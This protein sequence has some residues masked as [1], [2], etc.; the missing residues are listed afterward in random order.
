MEPR[1]TAVRRAEARTSRSERIHARRWW[2]LAVLDLAVFLVVLDDTILNVALPTLQR[3]LEATTSQLQWFLDSYLIVFGGLLLAAGSLGDRFGRRGALLTGWVVFGAGSLGAAVSTT[4]EQLITARCAMGLGAACIMPTTLSILT[5][6]FPPHERPLAIGLWAGVIGIGVGVGPVVSGALLER[7]WWGSVFLIN[8]P[9]VAVGLLST[10]TVVPDS[11]DPGAPRVDWP[12]V[13]LSTAGV[14]TL[15]YAIIEAPSHGWT[16][17]R[18]LGVGAAAVAVI[19][20][21]AWWERRADAPMIDPR[22]FRSARFTAASLAI[23]LTFFAL[24]G[25]LFV[26]TQQLQFVLGYSALETGLR[27]APVAV[28]LTV[29]A[30][31]SAP[32]AARLGAKARVAAGLASVAAGLAFSALGDGEYGTLLA[33]IAAVGLGMGL[34]M[35]PATDAV[36]GSLPLAKAGVGSAVND[37]TRQ[38]GAAFGVAVVGSVLASQYGDTLLPA[39]APLPPDLAEAARDSVGA[40]LAIAADAGA[41]AL[42]D[43]AREAYREAMRAALLVAAG[44]SA[45]GAA[46]ALAFLPAHERRTR[47]QIEAAF[48]STPPSESLYEWLLRR[49]RDVVAQEE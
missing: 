21:L 28:V 38:L 42:A 35:S 13:V 49:P 12:G 5:N 17:E 30:V 24:F 36:M 15:I 25:Y 26:I 33:G 41:G 16:S 18:T 32:L 27:V 39:L 29:G 47:E 20:V 3:E 8:V 22:F 9:V 48:A 6:V 31:A 10:T 46:L 1:E 2:T 43:A 11:R 45:V 4:P 23:A 14:A 40:T 44:V 19:G 34:A 7:F 37:T